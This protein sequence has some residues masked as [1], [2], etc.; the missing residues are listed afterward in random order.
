MIVLPEGIYHRFTLDTNNYIKVCYSGFHASA[1]LTCC[2]G[3][4]PCPVCI[5]T[6]SSLV[7]AINALSS[8]VLVHANKRAQALPTSA[9][10]S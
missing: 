8:S 7:S 5:W 2:L 3:A 10:T 6:S 9:L 1:S 4:A